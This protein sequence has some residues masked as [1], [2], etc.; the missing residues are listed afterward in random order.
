M[1]FRK[2]SEDVIIHVCIPYLWY[3]VYAGSIND[4]FLY[5][6]NTCIFVWIQQFWHPPL[7]HLVSKTCLNEVANGANFD[8]TKITQELHF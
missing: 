8:I 5:N 6:L 2:K 1:G 4:T 3:F 7:N